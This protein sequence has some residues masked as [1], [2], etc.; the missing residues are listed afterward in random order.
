M[1]IFA[2]IL[3]LSTQMTTIHNDSI[4]MSNKKQTNMRKISIL[5][6]VGL[7]ATIQTNAQTVSKPGMD[8]S[9]KIKAG[10]MLA[11]MASISIKK[12]SGFTAITPMFT[13]VSFTKGKT[14]VIP[15]YCFSVNSVNLFVTRDVTLK[16]SPYIVHMHGTA[17]KWDYTGIGATTPVT[18]G[19]ASMFVEFGSNWKQFNPIFYTGVYIPLKFKVR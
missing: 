12:P 3:I 15:S 14:T 4:I 17:S 18:N 5:A 2:S 1:S 10:I 8:N 6:L 13:V 19:L 7:I 9:L 11:P 16:F